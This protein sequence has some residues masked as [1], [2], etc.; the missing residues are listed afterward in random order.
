M[1]TNAQDVGRITMGEP[2]AYF[3]TWT[4][5]GTWLPGDERGW[6]DGTGRR[7]EP[8]ESLK[9][10]ASDSMAEPSFTLDLPQRSLVLRTIVAHARIREWELHA[11][12]CRSN[13]VHVVLSAKGRPPD[14][15]MSQFKA[16][17]TRRLREAERRSGPDSRRTRWWT[18]GGSGRY[19]NRR[20]ELDA[21]IA[22]VRGTQ[23]RKGIVD[24]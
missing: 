24:D 12:A 17:C 23:D 13:H 6:V 3:L 21:V 9:K 14:E 8:D 15:V 22:Y 19:M 20:S 4:T 11:L 7:R 1:S 2:L 10:T 5:Y 18:E 16:W